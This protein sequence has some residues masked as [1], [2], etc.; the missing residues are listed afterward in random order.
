M[1]QFFTEISTQIALAVG[2]ILATWGGYIF[3][4]SKQKAEVSGLE[5]END[6]KE[7]ENGDKL[8]KMYR[9]SLDDLGDRYE[10]KFK[11]V[12]DMY[13]MKINLLN[14]EINLHKRIVAQLKEEN[15]MLRTKI[16]D[17]E[18]SNVITHG[19]H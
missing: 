1:T 10:K 8:I 17:Y 13:E 2:T 19:S 3:G 5:V 12:T 6:G 9:E 15:A 4:R 18:K 7:I 11:D 16:K 14:D